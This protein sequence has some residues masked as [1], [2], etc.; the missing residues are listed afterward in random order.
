MDK[1]GAV[2]VDIVSEFKACE[3]QLLP[4]LIKVNM[5]WLPG[6]GSWLC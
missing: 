1:G 2:G 4:I 5:E 6:V 3:G